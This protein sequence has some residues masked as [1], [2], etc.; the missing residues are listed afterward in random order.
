MQHSLCSD[1][2]S[3]S[4]RQKIPYILWNLKGHYS[5]HNIHILSKIGPVHILS[6]YSTK[7][8][9]DTILPSALI[10]S[11]W[12][13]SPSFRLSHRSPVYTFALPHTWHILPD[14]IMCVETN[15]NRTVCSYSHSQSS[16]WVTRTCC[17]RCIRHCASEWQSCLPSGSCCKYFNVSVCLHFC[18]TP[19]PVSEGQRKAHYEE[20]DGEKKRN[21]DKIK[22]LKKEIK[23]LNGQL[24]ATGQVCY[25]A[26]LPNSNRRPVDWTGCG[27]LLSF[28]RTHKL[29]RQ[30]LNTL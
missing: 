12:S 9:F 6:S 7:I 29:L 13:L 23:N 27:A 4:A 24:S 20:L 18:C 2:N 15:Q 21:K 19:L 3:S 22:Q 26:E 16:A 10:S 30:S 28:T 1:S 11:K 14:M 5:V 17:V 8:H 25:S